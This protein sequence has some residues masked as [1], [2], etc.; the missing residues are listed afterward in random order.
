MGDWIKQR[1]LPRSRGNI[2][3]AYNIY[4]V[5]RALHNGKYE[6]SNVAYDFPVINMTYSELDRTGE[7]YDFPLI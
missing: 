7:L 2:P 5:K 6:R 4:G 3:N 1:R